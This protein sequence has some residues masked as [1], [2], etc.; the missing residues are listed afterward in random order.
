[1]CNQLC[2]RFLKSDSLAVPSIRRTVALSE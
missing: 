2:N 1:V